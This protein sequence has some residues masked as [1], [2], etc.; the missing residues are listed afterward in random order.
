MIKRSRSFFYLISPFLII[1]MV[2][3]RAPECNADNSD[4]SEIAIS[5]VHAAQTSVGYGQVSMGK[6]VSGAPISINGRIFRNAILAHAPS[7]LTFYPRGKFKYFKL[8]CGV[9][10]E[11]GRKGSVRFFIYLDDRLAAA[12][13]I[14]QGGDAAIPILLDIIKVS[15]VE[16]FISELGDNY[17]D[18]SVWAEP[19]FLKERPKGWSLTPSL[20]VDFKF[21]QNQLWDTGLKTFPNQF[22]LFAWRII[23]GI[24]YLILFALVICKRGLVLSKLTQLKWLMRRPEGYIL[25]LTAILSFWVFLSFWKAGLPASWDGAQH[26]FRCW[27]M[28]NLFLANFKIDGWSP[29]WYLGV[30]QFLFYSPFLFFLVALFHF[31]T[32]QL[33]PLVICYKI[34]LFSVYFFLPFACYWLMRQFDIEPLPSSLASL[35]VPAVSAIHGI[36]IEALCLSG[37]FTQLFGLL[38]FCL[39]VGFLQRIKKQRTS[40]V[41]ILAL[42]IGLLF[43]SHIITSIYIAFCLLVF[44]LFN[45]T[46]RKYIISVLTAFL[47]AILMASFVLWPTFYYRDLRGPETGWGDINFFGT[48]FSGAYFGPAAI[49][50]FAWL[51][52]LAACFSKKK[53]LIVLIFLAVITYLF[54]SNHLMIR[55]G[56]FEVISRQIFKSRTYPYLAIY[57]I[58]FSGFFYQVVLN[59][60]KRL[61]RRMSLVHLA[62]IVII[63]VN[64]SIK[65]FSLAPY[66][67]LDSDFSGFARDAYLQGFYWLRDNTPQNIV[68]AFDDRWKNV[69]DLGFNQFASQINIHANRYTLQGNQLELTRAH[70]ER[71]AENLATWPT[72]EI[73]RYLKRYNVSYLYSWNDDT[74][75]NLS[76]SPDLFKQVYYNGFVSIWQVIGHDFRYLGN[77]SQEIR[78]DDFYFSPEIVRWKILNK[79]DD[80]VIVAAVAYHPNWKLYLNDKTGKISKT[81]DDLISFSLPKKEQVYNVKLSFEKSFWERVSYLISFTTLVIVLAFLYR[82]KSAKGAQKI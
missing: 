32:F 76:S 29:Y 61:F 25:L 51:G 81:S 14:V 35:A 67:K 79:R 47:L 20:N 12:T 5:G 23:A 4:I 62:L 22:G 73:Y 56:I 10:D 70:N 78:I 39:A 65:L 30:Q 7:S 55:L 34:F 49:N 28:K 69:P 44:I 1:L 15:K 80:N 33:V 58:L 60:A 75:L 8:K 71:V 31:I 82:S 66:I 36:G 41:F 43:I 68:V 72:G 45:L 63:V 17:Y 26:Y 24:I 77:S 6:N 42:I 18:H 27:S 48:F 54:A 13:K 53:E 37:L 9:D 59:T 11:V 38:L 16:L 21:S 40:D 74:R 57:L 2:F 64:V 3:G 52:L 19:E 50:I 46:D